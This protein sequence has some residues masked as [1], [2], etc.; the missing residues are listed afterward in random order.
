MRSVV[1]LKRDLRLSDHR[2]LAEAAAGECL[3]LYVAEPSLRAAE[4]F[5]ACHADFVAQSLQDLAPR[6]A[7]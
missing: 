4:D 1:W 6:I 5:D 7:A 2:P 3:L